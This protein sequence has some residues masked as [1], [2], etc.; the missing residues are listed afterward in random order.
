MDARR[1]KLH[2]TTVEN[3][4][5]L[6]YSNSA[7]TVKPLTSFFKKYTVIYELKMTP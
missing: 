4:L 7:A 2:I 5:N 3:I 6:R 1:T